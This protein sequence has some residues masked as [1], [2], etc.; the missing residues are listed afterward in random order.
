MLDGD[1]P[2]DEE[3]LAEL[4]RVACILLALSRLLCR[5]WLC[6]RRI[7]VYLRL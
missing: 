3:Q 5:I 1:M 6:L 2:D 4:K 7:W